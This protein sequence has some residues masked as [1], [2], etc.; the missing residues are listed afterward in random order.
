MFLSSGAWVCSL[1]QPDE[2]HMWTYLWAGEA[3]GS[4]AEQQRSSGFA[5]VL[6]DE[7]KEVSRHP[8]KHTH[9]HAHAAP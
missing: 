4:S 3:K 7:G 8:P 5:A 1:Q 6:I 9:T 2:A